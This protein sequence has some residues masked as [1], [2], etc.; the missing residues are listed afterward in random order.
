MSCF[1]IH[2]MK[3]CSF[4]NNMY[5]IVC[6]YMFLV[7]PHLFMF[8]VQPHFTF[9]MILPIKKKNYSHHRLQIS[10]I[11]YILR[12]YMNSYSSHHNLNI[13]MSSICQKNNI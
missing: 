1:L 12:A 6:S 5:T 7:Q 4:I 3:A 10:S 13:I 2:T 8:L 11:E 9:T